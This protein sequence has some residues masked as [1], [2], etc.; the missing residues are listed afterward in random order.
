LVA[1]SGS[2]IHGNVYQALAILVVG[3]VVLA[4]GFIAALVTLIIR[5]RGYARLGVTSPN[6]AR[7]IVGRATIA[8]VQ[9]ALWAVLILPIVLGAI[10]MAQIAFPA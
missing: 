8:A 7:A 4:T 6:G 1:E 2:G 10:A 9:G 5:E 3:T